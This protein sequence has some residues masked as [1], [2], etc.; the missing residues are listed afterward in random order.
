MPR[1]MLAEIPES[2]IKA[3]SS[4][5]RVKAGR[6]ISAAEVELQNLPAVPSYKPKNMV[7]MK[8][9]PDTKTIAP[10]WLKVP[11]RCRVQMPASG[12]KHLRAIKEYF[13][14][15]YG[16]D[17]DLQQCSDCAV[18][19]LVNVAGNKGAGAFAGILMKIPDDDIYFTELSTRN[20][21]RLKVLVNQTKISQ[22][23]LMNLA[24][25]LSLEMYGLHD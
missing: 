13:A 23:K 10:S 21:V 17:L 20:Y 4:E 24:L 14:A 19:N 3:P 7:D 25:L 15:T 1:K 6:T 16:M 12:V 9:K 22:F 8:R 5:K 18:N 11:K 2:A